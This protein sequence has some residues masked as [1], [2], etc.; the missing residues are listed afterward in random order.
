MADLDR[1]LKINRATLQDKIAY[2]NLASTLEGK[3]WNT[4]LDIVQRDRYK[5]A[6]KRDSF[7]VVSETLKGL[8]GKKVDQK[9]GNLKD[10]DAEDLIE[11][12]TIL[13]TDTGKIIIEKIGDEIRKRTDLLI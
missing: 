4:A 2:G 10:I 5:G 8:F 3:D 9:K 11:G 12:F 13:T 7:L 1:A 6:K